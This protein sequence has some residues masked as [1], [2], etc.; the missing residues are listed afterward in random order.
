MCSFLAKIQKK[1]Q[2]GK[3]KYGEVQYFEKTLSY[4][5]NDLNQSGKVQNVPVVAGRLVQYQLIYLAP[6]LVQIL[7]TDIQEDLNFA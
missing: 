4:F 1:F 5:K 6:R 2:V 7:S 3:V